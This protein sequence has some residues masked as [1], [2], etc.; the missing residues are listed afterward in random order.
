MFRRWRSRRCCRH[1]AHPGLH[2]SGVGSRPGP[3]AVLTGRAPTLSRLSPPTFAPQTFAPQTFAPEPFCETF[4]TRFRRFRFRG[5]GAF[6]YRV[7]PW[8]QPPLTPHSL[9]CV[10]PCYRHSATQRPPDSCA[11]PA[12]HRQTHAHVSSTPH[13]ARHTTMLPCI[14]PSHP[15]AQHS[16]VQLSAATRDSCAGPCLAWPGLAKFVF[17]CSGAPRCGAPACP[18]G[19]S[20][21]RFAACRSNQR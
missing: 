8:P 21:P 7:E 6:A 19:T 14:L 10:P 9:Q 17:R 13:A 3:A 18:N 15:T 2:G 1:R 12:S 5:R 4:R 16:R 11:R 20:C